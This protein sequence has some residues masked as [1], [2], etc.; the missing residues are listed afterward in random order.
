[1]KIKVLPFF[2]LASCLISPLAFADSEARTSI[3]VEPEIL[4]TI[5]TLKI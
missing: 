2:T 1:M 5:E 3:F 4:E